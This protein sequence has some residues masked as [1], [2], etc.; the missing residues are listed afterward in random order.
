MTGMRIRMLLLVVLVCPSP[1]HAFNRVWRKSGSRITMKAPSPCDQSVV[2]ASFT[3]TGIH[4]VLEAGKNML[5]ESLKIPGAIV[6]DSKAPFCY[7]GSCYH[8]ECEVKVT[9]R[10]DSIVRLCL[11]EVPEG[12]EDS[13][14]TIEHF[15]GLESWD[16][17]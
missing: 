14:I 15:D 7:S 8:C 10:P 16:T 12:L 5:H 11:E 17:V 4:G 3:A 1:L 13:E 9:G 6:E 2:R